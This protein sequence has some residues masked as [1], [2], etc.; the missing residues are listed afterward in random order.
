MNFESTF[1]SNEDNFKEAFANNANI[2]NFILKI[3]NFI[4][5][6]NVETAMK[7]GNKNLAGVLWLGHLLERRDSLAKLDALK[8]YH[9][10]QQNKPQI[11]QPISRRTV[12]LQPNHQDQLKLLR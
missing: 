5:Y 11:I 9:S 8:T 3:K 7:L 12:T 6:S 2:F 4:Y 1:L 10:H